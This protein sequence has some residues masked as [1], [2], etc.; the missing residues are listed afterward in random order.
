MP[1]H[2]ILPHQLFDI[3]T[4]S[5]SI[6]KETKIILWEHPHYFT[7]YNYNK[8][9]LILHRASMKYYKDYLTSDGYIV[10]YKNYNSKITTKSYT[11]FDPIDKIELPFEY[12]LLE[13]PNFLLTKEDYGIYRKK[14]EKYLFNAF[15]MW[16]KKIVDIIPNVKSKDK[17]N[18]KKLP[19]DLII[20]PVPSNKED[21]KYIKP[22]I[23][24][25]KKH[26]P[27]NYGNVD[28][29][30]FPITHKTANK[31]KL[32][33]IKSKFEKFGDYQDSIRKDNEYLFH[34]L[35]SSSINIGLINPSDIIEQLRDYEDKIP[36]NCFEGYIRQL[37]WREYQRY[38]Y[39]YY[40]FNSKKYFNNNEKLTNKWYTGNTGI[41]PVDRAIQHGFDTGYLHHISRLMIIGNFMNI[42][43]ILPKEGFRWF[44]EFSCDS[45][46]WV[47][48]QNVYDMVFFVSGGATMRRPYISS[49]NYIL[50][51]SDYKKGEWCEVWDKLYHSFIEKNKKELYK[52]RYFI[53]YKK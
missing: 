22:A 52:F 10:Q 41:P 53:K 45:Y 47:M 31:W 29:F 15:Y 39:I 26:F 43:G 21:A 2:I 8:K 36:I 25:I 13:S 7:S 27:D 46:E 3:K 44:M 28:N 50:K 35:L 5:K 37:F 14:T 51:M 24:Y 9:K 49:S 1:Y 23:L 42:S 40:D 19:A 4:L 30:I 12:E 20:P 17:E 16:G 6:N 34:S 11:I 33:F 38:C 18:R 32:D 48:C